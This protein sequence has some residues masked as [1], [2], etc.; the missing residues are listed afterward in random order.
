MSSDETDLSFDAGFDGSVDY[1]YRYYEHS[2]NEQHSIFLF[3]RLYGF[4]VG[5][6]TSDRL[7]HWS[8]K[9]LVV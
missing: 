4:S 3:H 8:F 1:Y 2:G 6:V 7:N 9:S 5:K